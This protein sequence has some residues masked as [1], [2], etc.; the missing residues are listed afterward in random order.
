MPVDAK[1]LAEVQA[2]GWLII[3]ADEECVIGS[4]RR[5]GCGLKA[6]FK[7][8][9]P[10]P[11]TERPGPSRLE[12]VVSGFEDSRKFLGSRRRDLGLTIA[13]T[14]EIAGMAQDYLAKFERENPSKI[15]NAITFIEW[16]QGLGYEVVLRPGDLGRMALRVIAE[17]RLRAAAR[18][19]MNDYL[20]KKKQAA[21]E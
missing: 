20:E 10:I 1:L 7:A 2:A 21:A 18:A 15:P 14:E 6:T 19:N 5:S 16:A 8:G 12:H 3:R 17:T 9:R 4:C 11:A 13:E